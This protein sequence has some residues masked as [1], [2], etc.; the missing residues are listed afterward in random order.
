MIKAETKDG[1]SQ[2]QK[3]NIEWDQPGDFL[4]SGANLLLIR[5]LVQ[6]KF[7]GCIQSWQ[8]NI[9]GEFSLSQHWFHK[10]DTMVVIDSSHEVQVVDR[11]LISENEEVSR[12]SS[13][14][15]SDNGRLLKEMYT[16]TPRQIHLSPFSEIPPRNCVKDLHLNW[17]SD[18]QLMSMFLEFKEKRKEELKQQLKHPRMKKILTDYILCLVKSKPKSVMDFTVDF[19]RKL[20]R[21]GNA[22]VYETIVAISKIQFNVFLQKFS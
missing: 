9:N 12:I 14:F 15:F 20:E 13:F 19:V 16:K 21:D 4:S 11:L 10:P 5:R 2:E 17:E 3:I 18:L 22:Q 1:E 8:C 6:D 7:V